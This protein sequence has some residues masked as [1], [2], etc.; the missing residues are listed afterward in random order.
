MV[1]ELCSKLEQLETPFSRLR[2]LKNPNDLCKKVIPWRQEF[3]IFREV[4]SDEENKDKLQNFNQDANVLDWLEDVKKLADD[5]QEILHE[6]AIT[7]KSSQKRGFL[8]RCRNPVADTTFTEKGIG[9]DKMTCSIRLSAYAAASD[10]EGIDKIVNLVESIPLFCWTGKFM[11]LQL[12]GTQKLGFWTVFANAKKSEGLISGKS[13]SSAAKAYE[14]LLRQYAT[15]GQK[16]E[17]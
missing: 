12:V 8:A 9:Y 13:R 14:I 17:V 1:Q 6:I 3:K 2:S 5:V 7:G 10:V 15:T 16:D 4:N 11:E